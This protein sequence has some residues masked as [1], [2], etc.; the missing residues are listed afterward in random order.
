MSQLFLFNNTTTTEN[1]IIDTNSKE[2]K[3]CPKCLKE[4]PLKH[5][6]TRQKSEDN[7]KTRSY[8][9]CKQC[10]KEI[11]N[12]LIKLK[13]ENPRT[14]SICE[15]CGK[16]AKLYLDHCHKTKNFR[17]WICNNCNIGLSRLGD[18]ING[19]VTAINYLIKQ[20]NK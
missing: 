4:K 17:G 20:K 2:N 15:C 11:N 1:D 10:E 12:L 7:T 9:N 13:S 14:D 5:F 16:E 19:L 8:T 3:I 6:R 18:D